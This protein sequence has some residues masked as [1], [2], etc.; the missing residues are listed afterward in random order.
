MLALPAMLMVLLIGMGQQ[1]LLHC[2][3]SASVPQ[4]P[5]PSVSAVDVASEAEFLTAF[6]E[7]AVEVSDR[8]YMRYCH[9]QCMA[10]FVWLSRFA[11]STTAPEAEMADMSVPMLY[12]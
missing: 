8:M 6:G 4:E 5:S 10:R 11:K 12:M 2:A 3:R 7:L 9:H 1:G